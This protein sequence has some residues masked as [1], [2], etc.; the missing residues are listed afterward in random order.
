M[1]WRIP[2]SWGLTPSKIASCS[3][4]WN[5]V[6]ASGPP[7]ALFHVAQMLVPSICA[8]TSPK[9]SG[10]LVWERKDWRSHILFLKCCPGRTHLC[11][12]YIPPISSCPRAAFAR[13]ATWN[14]SPELCSVSQGQYHPM[15]KGQ[16][17]LVDPAH[18]P[19]LGLRVSEYLTSL[20]KWGL[21]PPLPP[22]F[23]PCWNSKTGKQFCFVS[24]LHWTEKF[25][26]CDPISRVVCRSITVKANGRECIEWTNTCVV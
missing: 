9:A 2:D 6:S 17:L 15:K 24:I 26:Y 21:L 16:E 12:V 22:F 18:L 20:F 23:G 19:V 8:Q 14:C 11:P 10:S 7:T 13:K 3:C 4:S 25:L 1:W 5:S